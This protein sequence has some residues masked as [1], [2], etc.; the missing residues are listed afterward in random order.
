ML[1]PLIQNMNPLFRE[2]SIDEGNESSSCYYQHDD[3]T[4]ISRSV[5]NKRFVQL[6]CWVKC[7]QNNDVKNNASSNVNSNM[8]NNS[9]K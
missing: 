1:Y 8:N 4:H 7:D 6:M 9:N 3:E 2:I 5:S